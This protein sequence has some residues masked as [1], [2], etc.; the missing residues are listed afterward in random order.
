MSKIHDEEPQVKALNRLE[1]LRDE[2]EDELEAFLIAWGHTKKLRLKASVNQA[3]GSKMLHLF[4]AD[5]EDCYDW[6][7]FEIEIGTN[8]R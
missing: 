4:D 5:Q 7:A 8:E 3:Y 1:E 2:L 6:P